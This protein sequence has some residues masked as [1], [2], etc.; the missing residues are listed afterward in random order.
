MTKI[1]LTA[2]SNGLEA[3]KNPT[4]DALCDYLSSLGLTPVLSPCLY[5][6]DPVHTSVFSGTA[7]ER[8]EALMNFYRDPEV[9]AIFDLSGGDMA[10]EIL[11]HLD[12]ETI[13]ESSAVFWGYSDLTT[14]LNAIYAKTGKSSVLYQARN[15]V[16]EAGA[17]RRAAFENTI[18]QK[19]S[20]LFQIFCKY[21]QQGQ[22]QS[23]LTGTVVGGN[24]RCFLKLAGTEYWPD[25]QDKIFLLEAWSGTVPKM[26]TYLSQLQQLG[27]FRQV[28]AVL[29][30]TFTEMEQKACAPTIEELVRHYA[31]PDLPILKTREVGHDK[32]ALA[33]RIG[34]RF[35]IGG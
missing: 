18:L 9:K 26:V 1:A 15:L 2:C 10:N 32:D 21:V 23:P 33:V 5:E 28:K 3:R 19:K 31:G 22:I 34:G 14:I 20:D 17:F 25:M 27:V 4:V 35:T 16:S 11:P 8:A 12:F 30:G 13:A 29:L 6:K 7:E 24:I